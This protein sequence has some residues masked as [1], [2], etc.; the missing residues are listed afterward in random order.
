MTPRSGC[1]AAQHGLGD[2]SP[3]TR[4]SLL[5]P[6]SDGAEAGAPEV[7]QLIDCEKATED[8]ESDGE[9]RDD[10]EGAEAEEEGAE[11]DGDID[12]EEGAEGEGGEEGGGEK[13]DND[14]DKVGALI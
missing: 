9:E 3:R 12:E 4:H 13:Y 1:T 7:R 11:E 8:P 6:T 2:C 14:Q 10:Q 5:W